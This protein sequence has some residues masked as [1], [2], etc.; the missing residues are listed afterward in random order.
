VHVHH[1]HNLP[2]H[3]NN[4]AMSNDQNDMFGKALIDVYLLGVCNPKGCVHSQP[5]SHFYLKEYKEP[6]RFLFCLYLFIF[7]FILTRV[8]KESA[9]KRLRQEAREKE[10]ERK[11]KVL[12]GNKLRKKEWN[13]FN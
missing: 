12:E 9:L 10:V 5:Q 1:Y 7:F 3:D 4:V 2:I 8:M 11:P 13:M 6:L